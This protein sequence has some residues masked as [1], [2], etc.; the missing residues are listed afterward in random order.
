M[1]VEQNSILESIFVS[2]IVTAAAAAATATGKYTTLGPSPTKST[3]AHDYA[4]PLGKYWSAREREREK[5]S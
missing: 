3:F 1:V 2:S 4:G 5:K